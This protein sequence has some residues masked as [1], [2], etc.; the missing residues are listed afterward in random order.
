MTSTDYS[1]AVSDLTG[2]IYNYTDKSGRY[3]AS[4]RW[5]LVLGED[6]DVRLHCRT[7]YGGD[8]TPED[9]WHGRTRRWRIGSGEGVI[10]LDALEADLG[11]DGRL[12]LLIDRIKAGLEIYWNGNNHV[13]RLTDDANDAEV[14]LL[15]L[16][17]GDT[18]IDQ[19]IQVWEAADYLSGS[20]QYTEAEILDD[21]NLSALDDIDEE[22][23]DR[24]AIKVEEDALGDNIILVGAKEAIRNCIMRVREDLGAS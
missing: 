9:E 14:E 12:S 24:A 10:D 3:T 13:G 23:L 17:Y 5:A 7:Y 6:G 21:A 2:P 15:D 4:D 22:R 11:P 1:A 19:S 20:G 16:F 8:G 18:Y